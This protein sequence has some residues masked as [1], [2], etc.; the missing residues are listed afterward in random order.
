MTAV[1]ILAVG[2]C[3][4]ATQARISGTVVDTGGKPIKGA[5][6][7]ITSSELP[8]YAKE[9]KTD[10]DGEYKVMILDATKRYLFHVEAPG[11]AA[12]EERVKVGVGSMDNEIDFTLRSQKEMAA[13]QQEQLRQQPGYK[14][15]E[16][17]FDLLAEGNK[18]EARAK[19]QEA[20]AALPDNL[21]AWSA[22]A[23]LDYELE[24]YEQ[25]LA[26]AET[27]LEL[28]DEASNCLALAANASNRLGRT[29]QHHQYMERYQSLNPDD[30]ATLFNQA[31]EHLNAMDD[32]K[33]RP[34]LEQCLEID[35]TFPKC[36][37]EYG[38]VL[39]RAG[40]LEGAKAHL[41]R[42]LEAAPDGDDAATARETIK[43][44]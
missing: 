1:V 19:L 23:E 2:T 25:A 35:P 24:D 4:A 37:F 39:L 34:F 18:L 14:E 17:G 32:E 11:F 21:Q 28:D 6:I 29:E 44:L 36:L 8:S 9:L 3:W 10:A 7:T 13:A 31:V 26:H 5:V 27:C 16:E 33:A 40:D 38:M 43:Y 42:Y 41:E 30:P 20:V 12:Y 22:L 15:L